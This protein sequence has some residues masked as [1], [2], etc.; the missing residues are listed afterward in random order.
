MLAQGG[1]FSMSTWKCI[2]DV[3][4]SVM[5]VSWKMLL[6]VSGKL[7]DTQFLENLKNIK[8]SIEHLLTLFE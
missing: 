8:L 5:G 3:G 1:E 7:V 6:V 4:G 2:L